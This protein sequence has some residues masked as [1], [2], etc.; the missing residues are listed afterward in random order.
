MK[1]LLKK[2]YALFISSSAL[3]WHWCW[4]VC[5]SECIISYWLRLCSMHPSYKNW[6]KK[7]IF[8]SSFL[9]V[10]TPIKRVRVYVSA[11]V[12]TSPY[13]YVHICL[14]LTFVVPF[15]NPL[16]LTTQLHACPSHRDYHCASPPV[17][18]VWEMDNFNVP[19]PEWPL[20]CEAKQDLSWALKDVPG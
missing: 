10:T 13:T 1:L 11:T 2:Q 19:S 5:G 14:S 3:S 4:F 7:V 17:Q 20:P 9:T 18:F 15:L 16:S 6:G 8:F 12:C